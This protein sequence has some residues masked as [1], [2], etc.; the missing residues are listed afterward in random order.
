MRQDVQVVIL[1]S[2]QHFSSTFITWIDIHKYI[3]IIADF[4][5]YLSL[6]DMSHP[7]LMVS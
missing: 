6:E 4:G 2:P 3:F 7:G 1:C 5:L